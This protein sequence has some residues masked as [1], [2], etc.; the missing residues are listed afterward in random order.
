MEMYDM[1]YKKGK[2]GH[3]F[4]QQ[5]GQQYRGEGW[6]TDSMPDRQKADQ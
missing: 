1:V 3:S 5:G 4:R 2:N 6:G